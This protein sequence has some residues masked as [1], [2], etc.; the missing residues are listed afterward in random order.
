[1]VSAKMADTEY[2]AMWLFMFL[3]V[4]ALLVYTTGRLVWP[5]GLITCCAFITL[6]LLWCVG[7]QVGVNDG[8]IHGT[9]AY[10]MVTTENAPIYESSGTEENGVFVYTPTNRT[11]AKGTTYTDLYQGDVTGDYISVNMTEYIKT[12]DLNLISRDMPGAAQ[13]LRE[14]RV[15][16]SLLPR[17]LLDVGYGMFQACPMGFSYTK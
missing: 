14:I 16:E 6:V 4:T 12:A 8:T 15:S 17:F 10:A 2:S 5:I 13:A 1:M 9:L 11:A 7:F 3:A